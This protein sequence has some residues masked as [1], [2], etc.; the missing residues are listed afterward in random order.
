M[1]ILKVKVEKNFFLK[2]SHDLYF[3]PRFEKLGAQIGPILGKILG[4]YC[5][6]GEVKLS[7]LNSK[8]YGTPE[9]F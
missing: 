8:K 2:L 3:G 4:P 1:P 6:T 5:F 7:F 9:L